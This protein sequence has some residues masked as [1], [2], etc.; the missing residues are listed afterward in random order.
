VGGNTINAE[1]NNV[2]GASKTGVSSG[3]KT[4]PVA[5][6]DGTGDNVEDM[7]VVM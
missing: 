7:A 6:F 2:E 1:W 3:P 5:I 4:C